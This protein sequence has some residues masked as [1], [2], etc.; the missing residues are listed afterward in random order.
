MSLDELG[1]H[2]DVTLNAPDSVREFFLPVPAGVPIQGATLQLD[3]GYIRGDGGRTTMLV[4]LDGSPVLA[5]ALTQA[6]GQAAANVGVDGAPR[7]AGYV[8]VGVGYASV[9]ND[10]VCADQTAI[11]NVLR[12]DPSTRLSYRFDPADIR[13]LRTA[14][15]ALP[16]VPTVAVAS[17]HLDATP[18]DTAWRVDAVLDRDSKQPL[19]QAL[20]AVGD[21][22]P[23]HLAVADSNVLDMLRAVPA[24]AAIARAQTAQSDGTSAAKLADAAQAG[25][26]IALAP[27][28]VFN[29]DV[30]V[31]DDAM[32]ASA[33]A[34]LDALRG[35][36][37]VGV[38]RSGS[39]IRR[40][41]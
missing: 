36:G 3:G 2:T 18:F 10:N 7:D 23:S 29:P 9:I 25:A 19:M 12:I 40:M 28:N 31:A 16:H 30:V 35:T 20:P 24:F 14:W 37:H 17:R 21:V 22:I 13:D 1:L 32:R 26:M 27:R 11:G 41:A 4:S 15:S 39:S 38:A 34:S 33:H 6:D 8:R 5:R